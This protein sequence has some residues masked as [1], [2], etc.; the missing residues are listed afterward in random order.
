MISF[1]K[2]G[3]TRTKLTSGSELHEWEVTPRVLHTIWNNYA[4]RGTSARYGCGVESQN[5]WLFPDKSNSRR[6]AGKPGKSSM[7]SKNKFGLFRTS[8]KYTASEDI[9]RGYRESLWRLID[10]WNSVP[11]SEFFSSRSKQYFARFMNS[12]IAAKWSW[13]PSEIFQ[14]AASYFSAVD[15]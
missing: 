3:W 7:K 10:A 6:L 1:L 4:M 11:D 5:A 9:E 12:V 13:D 8:L 2:F 14:F 15:K